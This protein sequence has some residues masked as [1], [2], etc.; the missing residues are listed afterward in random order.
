MIL[1]EGRTYKLTRE[2]LKDTIDIHVHA[3]PHLLSSPRRMDSYEAAIEARDAG[4]QAIV[5]MDNLSLS[6]GTSYLINRLVPDFKTYGGLI[7]SSTYGGLNPRAVKTAISYGDGAKFISFGTHS[8]CYQALNEGRYIDGKM[9]PIIERYP[10]FE[11]EEAKKCIRIPTDEPPGRELDEILQLI[12][13]NPHIYLITGH[14]SPEESLRIVELS[15]EYGYEK[16]VVSSLSASRASIEQLKDMTKKGAFIEYQ[17]ASYRRSTPKTHYY[18]EKEY[19]SGGDPLGIML[20]AKQVQDLGADH[21][22]ACSDF[23]VYTGPTAVEGMREFIA[24]L[25]DLGISKDD[26]R[27][28]TKKN[29]EKLLGLK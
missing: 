1:P 19:A 5:Y 4:M 22:I 3:G 8:T 17:L 7:L 10:K 11:E 29:P 24:S 25:L 13:A 27:K 23:G 16:I 15:E 21:C 6:C 20:V 18:A 28:L 2:L 9:I 26:I 14:V 12:A